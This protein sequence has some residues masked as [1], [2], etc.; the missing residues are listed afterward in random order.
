MCSRQVDSVRTLLTVD[1]RAVR[2][3]IF[4]PDYF[5]LL[6]ILINVFASHVDA[7]RAGMGLV[8][9]GRL[10]K[11]GFQGMTPC[12]LSLL[13]FKTKVIFL[14]ERQVY[15]STFFFK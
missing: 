1:G 12:L 5:L 7:A 2:C 9:V 14:Q 11:L 10:K 3:S 4:R 15:T 6:T 13:E 8:N